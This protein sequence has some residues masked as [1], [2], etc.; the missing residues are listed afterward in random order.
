[1]QFALLWENQNLSGYFNAQKISLDL[2][3]YDIFMI[4]YMPSIAY[5]TLFMTQMSFK[6]ATGFENLLDASIANTSLWRTFA[7]DDTGITFTAGRYGTGEASD[8]ACMPVRIYG[9]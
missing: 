3:K 7:V 1:M 8:G 6:T 2:S 4:E 5:P 9:K